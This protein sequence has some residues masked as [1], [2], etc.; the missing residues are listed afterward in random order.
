MRLRR[1][2]KEADQEIK[3]KKGDIEKEEYILRRKRKRE[4]EKE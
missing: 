1:K 2:K 3:E 4:I